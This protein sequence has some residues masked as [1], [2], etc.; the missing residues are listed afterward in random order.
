MTRKKG[1]QA[2]LWTQIY[3][4]RQNTFRKSRRVPRAGST[5]SDRC[6]RNRRA[7][8]PVMRID[9]SLVAALLIGHFVPELTAAPAKAGS[10]NDPTLQTD[11]NWIDDRWQKTEIG[12]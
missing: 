5:L 1:P 6:R 10:I 4:G 8:F 7:A 9:L 3:L 11:A 12:P 2:F